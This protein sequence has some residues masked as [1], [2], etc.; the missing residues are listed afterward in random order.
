[1]GLLKLYIGISTLTA[2]VLSGMGFARDVLLGGGGEWW[3]MGV[4]CLVWGILGLMVLHDLGQL[5]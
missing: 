3:L 2:F 1:M 4:T 5:W